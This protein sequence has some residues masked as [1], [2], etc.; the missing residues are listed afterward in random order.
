[1]L[2]IK[3]GRVIDPASGTDAKRHIC[4]V[5]TGAGDIK[6]INQSDILLRPNIIK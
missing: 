2:L 1:M 5:D 3:N 4:V 6:T